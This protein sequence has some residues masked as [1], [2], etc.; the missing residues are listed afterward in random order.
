MDIRKLAELLSGSTPPQSILSE[1]QSEV[2]SYRRKSQETGTTLSIHVTGEDFHYTVNREN[3]KRLL[4]LYLKG[5]LDEVQLEYLSN[6]IDLSPSIIVA[7]EAVEDAI[8]R[9]ADPEV[10]SELNRETVRQIQDGL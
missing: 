2:E 10:N 4:D 3:I 8:F 7:D 6:V 9:L 5:L 1:I